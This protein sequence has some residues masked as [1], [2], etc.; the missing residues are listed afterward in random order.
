[1]MGRAPF[2]YSD[3]PTH[4]HPERKDPEEITLKLLQLDPSTYARDDRYFHRFSR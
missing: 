4:R 2:Q 1:M 3:T